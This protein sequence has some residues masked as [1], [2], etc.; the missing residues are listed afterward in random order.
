MSTTTLPPAPA[1]SPGPAPAK[2]AVADEGRI[3]L[4]A[5]LRHIGALARRNLLQ[6]KKDPESMFDVLM[7]ARHA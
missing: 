2:P 3:G 6:I 1:G 7:A 4:R 5:N